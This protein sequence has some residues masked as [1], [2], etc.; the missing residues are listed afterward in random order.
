MNSQPK[1]S[2]IMPVYN[3]ERYI[4]KAVTSVLKQTFIDFELL[5]INDGTKD[6]SVAQ[7]ERFVADT[8]VQWHH[9]ENGGLSDARNFGLQKAQG[10]YIY[11]MD[12]DDWIEPDLLE[13]ALQHIRQYDVLVFGYQ[14]DT[15]NGNGEM[16]QTEEVTTED[17]ILE[18]GK[19]QTAFTEK[20]LGLLGYAWNKLY[21]HQFLKDNQLFFPKGIS[22][23][24]DILFNAQVLAK[25]DAIVFCNQALYH[26]INRP[27][28]TLIKT[29]HANSFALYLQKDE[30]LNQFLSVWNFS[31]NDKKTVLANSLMLGLRYCA[32]NLFA[33]KNNLSEREK[34]N[35]LKMMLHNNRM[36]ELIVYYQPQTVTDK[37]YKNI[38]LH[39]RVVFLFA[40]CKM[41][42]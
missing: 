25:T 9:K 6:N 30:A 40:L 38:V 11:F 10:E 21:K 20:Q 16:I 39:K 34:F 37:L 31:V 23:V 8:R 27:V 29:F 1:I 7:T 14:L 22:L 13:V 41:L 19:Q 26:Y 32:N 36:Q 18:K 12:S 33:F 28:T 24:E 3:V 15:E 42:K 17:T 5:L 2:V 4:E 35:Y